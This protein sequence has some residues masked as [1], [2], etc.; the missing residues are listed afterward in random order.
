MAV[1]WRLSV[2]LKLVCWNPYIYSVLGVRAFWAKLS[3]KR[4]CW[5][6]P[7]KK[8]KIL[9]DNWILVSLGSFCIF[10]GFLFSPLFLFFSFF[11]F[12]F[13]WGFKGQ[14]RWPEGLPHLALNP[15]YLFSFIFSFLSFLEGVLFCLLFV[16]IPFLFFEESHIFPLKHGF[17]PSPFF[18]I[19]F[20][21]SVSLSLSLS[22]FFSS[23]LPSFFFSCLLSFCLPSLCLFVYFSWFFVF[24]WF[25]P[26]SWFFAF[27]SWKN[28]LKTLH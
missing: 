6:P 16:Y 15:P 11:V 22:L 5:T 21:V 27:V 12:V 10:V 1:S 8:K 26:F 2:F 14:V 28:N 17:F 25:F 13:I 20:S 9:T 3:K 23:F 19:S 7:S 24:S 18:T 4:N